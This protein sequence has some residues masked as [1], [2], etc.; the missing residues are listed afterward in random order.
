MQSASGCHCIAIVSTTLCCRRVVV[1]GSAPATQAASRCRSFAV[2]VAVLAT[3]LSGRLHPHSQNNGAEDNDRGDGGGRHAYICGRDEGGTTTPSTNPST[4][5]KTTITTVAASEDPKMCLLSIFYS[6]DSIY[7]L[8]LTIYWQ[9]TQ[10]IVKNDTRS[11]TI[12]NIFECY[13]MYT[14]CC[15]NINFFVIN[16]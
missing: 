13:N 2:V 4:S 3:K 1:T 11:H 6:V 7:W 14:S 16:C 8:N 12:S 10:F 5:T 9:M 15:S